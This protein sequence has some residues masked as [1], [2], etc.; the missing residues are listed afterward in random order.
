MTFLKDFFVTALSS[1]LIAN[2]ILFQIFV[3]Y[4]LKNDEKVWHPIS[5]L[6]WIQLFRKAVPSLDMLQNKRRIRTCSKFLT[7]W[8]L[9]NFPYLF[10]PIKFMG[11][12]YSDESVFDVKK[13]KKLFEVNESKSFF[14]CLFF[15]TILCRPQI[16]HLWMNPSSISTSCPHHRSVTTSAT[17]TTK[18]RQIVLRPCEMSPLSPQV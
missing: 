14:F 17:T 4:V 13:W 1:S 11:K 2:N 9:T 10:Y 18:C 5:N 7:C 15:Q 16:I 12:K 8:K 3:K 6:N